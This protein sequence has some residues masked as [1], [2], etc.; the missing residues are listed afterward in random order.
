MRLSVQLLF[1]GRSDQLDNQRRDQ[2]TL[3]LHRPGAV[4][5]IPLLALW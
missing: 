5:A 1:A 2:K 4:E 3:H